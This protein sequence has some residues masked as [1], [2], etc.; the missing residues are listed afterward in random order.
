[1]AETA[2][3]SMHAAS[4]QVLPAIIAA[5]GRAPRHSI[6][7]GVT[8]L[9]SSEEATALLTGMDVSTVV[10]LRGRAIVAVMT[11]NF[12]RGDGVTV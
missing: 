7:K 4:A 8:L 3:V 2:R 5:P 1:M 12:R 11:H 6:T 9:L 10:G